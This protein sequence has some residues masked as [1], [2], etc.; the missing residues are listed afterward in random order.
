LSLF[1]ELPRRGLLGTERSARQLPAYGFT[2]NERRDGYEIDE[3]QM[4]VVRRIIDMAVEGI[5]FK[6]MKHV[7]ERE[8]IRTPQGEEVWD[9]AFFRRCNGAGRARMHFAAPATVG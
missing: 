9:R 1:P 2:P 6:A 8:G 4:E 3:P 5:F 7:F